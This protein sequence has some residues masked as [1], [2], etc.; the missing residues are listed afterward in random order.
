M[1]Y[2]LIIRRSPVTIFA[3]EN[4]KLLQ[5]LSVC[6]FGFSLRF[7]TRIAHASYHIFICD[8][9]GSTRIFPHYVIKGTIFENNLQVM[10]CV[11]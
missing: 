6:L 1:H 5:I 8:Q 7:P 10:K 3:L 9:S 2:N 4:Y 11:F